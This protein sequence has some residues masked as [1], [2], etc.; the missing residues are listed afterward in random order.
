MRARLF[1]NASRYNYSALSV[2]DLQ[3]LV[4]VNVL[5]GASEKLRNGG[6]DLPRPLSQSAF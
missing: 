5:P 2:S 4:G 6:M 1:S 3:K